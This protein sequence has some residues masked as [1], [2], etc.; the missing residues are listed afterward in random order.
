[1]TFAEIIAAM[2]QYENSEEYKKFV[3]SL[4]TPERVKAFLDTEA[5]QKALH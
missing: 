1:M 3:D 4:F 2:K 5:G